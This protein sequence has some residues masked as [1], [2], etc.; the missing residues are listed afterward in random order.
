MAEAD[1]AGEELPVPIDDGACDHLRRRRVP[2]M[3][4][5]STA[6]EKVDLSTLKGTSVVYVYP[7]IGHPDQPPGPEW[8]GIP[9]AKG[10][11]PEA[12]GFRNHNLE[13]RA[14]G[15][16]V[17]GLSAQPLAEQHEAHERLGLT[18]D[19]LNDSDLAFAT[20]LELPTFEFKGQ[21]YIQR[22]TLVVEKG[23]ITKVFYPVFPPG[24]HAA[25]VAAWLEGNR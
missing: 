1:K 16:R 10:C 4:L 25:E 17:F 6:G 3:P 24:E 11:T 8:A 22:L 15:V 5:A 13:W 12:C 19:L 21:T 9:G 14:L 18:F 7:R 20:A 2:A 23:V